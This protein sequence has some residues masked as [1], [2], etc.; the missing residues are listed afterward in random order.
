VVPDGFRMVC[1][2]CHSSLPLLCDAPG[3]PFHA[4]Q[5]CVQTGRN[6]EGVQFATSTLLCIHVA[7]REYAKEGAA[8]I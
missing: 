2:R 6:H 3:S 4:E 8:C 7:L 5:A 1:T